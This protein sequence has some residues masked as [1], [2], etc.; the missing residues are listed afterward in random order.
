MSNPLKQLLPILLP[1][2]LSGC[3]DENSAPVATGDSVTLNQGKST[4]ID[5]LQ[6]D[7]DEDHDPLVVV[8]ETPPS[9]GTLIIQ[10]DGLVIYQHDGSANGFDSFTYVTYDGAAYSEPAQVQLTIL[11]PATTEEETNVVINQP[12][13]AVDDQATV[14]MGSRITL[15]LLN[16][17][18]DP[19]NGS[20]RIDNLGNPTHGQVILA[21]NGD[22][23]YQHDGSD[24]S[25]DRFRYTISN[26][27]NLSAAANVTI[28]ITRENRAP[29]FTHQ[30]HDIQLPVDTLYE[31][32]VV[33][34]D[35]D[36]DS[37][38]FTVSQLPYWLDFSTATHTLTGQASWTEL[39]NRYPIVITVDDGELSNDIQF[40]ITVVEPRPVTDTAT[41]RLLL[42]TTYGPTLGDIERVKQLGV[43]AW[44]DSQLSM[45]S[46]YSN[47]NDGWLSH[48]QRTQEIATQAEP[49]NDWFAAGVFNQSTADGSALDYQMAAWWENALGQ[50]SDPNSEVGSDQLRQRVAYALSQLLVTSNSV[51]VLTNRG[52][53]LAAYY[54]LLAKHAFGNYRTLLGEV[55]RSPA[56]GVYLSHQGNR[57]ANPSTGTRPDENFAREVIQLFS[58]GLY[59]LNLDGSPNLDGDSNSYPDPGNSLVPT[60]EQ[61]DIEE[62][63]KVMTGWDLAGNSSFGRLSNKDGDYTQPMVFHPE[64][65]EDELADAGDGYVTLF[66]HRFAL[67]SGSDQS[68]LDTALDLLF[69]HPNV[70]PYVSRHLIQRLVTSNPSSA[71]L[72]RVSRVFNNNGNGVKGDLKAVVRAILL[73]PE[74]RDDRHLI[75]PS[76]GK[77]KEPVLAYTH[78]LRALNT[79]PLDGWISQSGVAMHGVYWFRSPQNSLGQAAL[80]SPSVFNFYSPNHIPRDDRFVD[81][82][83]VAPELQIQTDQMLIDYSNLIYKTLDRLEK[84]RIIYLDGKTLAEFGASHNYYTEK[85]FLTNFDKE[86]TIFEQALEGDSNRDFASIDDSSVD[87]DGD[88]PK[89]NA[90]DALLTHLDLLLLGGQMSTEYKSALKHYLLLSAGTNQSNPFAE[91]RSLVRDAVTMIVTSSSYMIQK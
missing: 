49:D 63:A 66:G 28:T 69:N 47:A 5:V 32:S 15:D 29:S 89:A 76:Y 26:A 39:G 65:H 60:Y 27:S 59:E 43:V 87:S 77:A 54:D 31:F 33:A 72:A 22:V 30:P 52:E 82:N 84:N 9:H 6:N 38:N 44:I 41:H 14:A 74:A 12:P 46:A 50:P 21:P 25:S 56:M 1:L 48:L 36:G 53:A 85:I 20:L 2:V 45:K 18:F 34:E 80:R 3:L 4:T 57:K 71:Y 13:V 75:D 51:P 73:D 16:N 11:V 19:E 35:P 88:T 68:G 10:D 62:L 58:I 37:L 81:Y 64:Y 23:T 61:N 17:D 7:K 83:L 86:L 42:Q 55:A 78:L 91:V 8:V 67:N 40:T 70:A 79:T 24:S 90:I